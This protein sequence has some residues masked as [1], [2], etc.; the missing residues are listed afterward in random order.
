MHEITVCI[1]TD[2]T[3]HASDE[4]SY[5]EP[6]CLGG[7]VVS[8]RPMALQSVGGAGALHGVEGEL[9]EHS[10]SCTHHQKRPSVCK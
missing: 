2:R 4:W 9:E 7:C 1:P 10:C 6:L 5:I 8:V 3:H